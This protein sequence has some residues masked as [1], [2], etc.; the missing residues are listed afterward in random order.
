MWES[1]E[2]STQKNCTDAYD[3]VYIS[4]EFTDSLKPIQCSLVKNTFFGSF[5][6]LRGFAFFFSGYTYSHSVFN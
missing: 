1:Y 3:F 5:L 4:K 2:S 6:I